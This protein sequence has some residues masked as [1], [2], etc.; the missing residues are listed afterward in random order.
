MTELPASLRPALTR[1][2]R[3]LAA[4]LFLDV[5]P[6]WAAAAL[7]VAG[8]VALVCRL[9]VPGAAGFLPWLWLAPVVAAVP[10][11]IV[12]A[13]RAFQPAQ[14]VA[15]ADSLSGGHGLLISMSER[16]DAAWSQSPLLERLAT[17]Q[18]PRLRPW[19]R[20][21]LLAP[22]LAFLAGALLLPQRIPAP[23][24]RGVLAD[25]IVN[26]LAATVVA[27]KKQE[28]LTPEEEKTLAEEIEQ[29]RQGASARVDSSSWEAADALKE[30]LA[31]SVGEKQDA[32]P[33]RARL[34]P[35]KAPSS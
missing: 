7:L 12:C 27:L 3:R 16:G 13:R 8:C 23:D 34:R 31:A 2:S 6:A 22:A 33:P 18:M 30:R 1:L 32:I 11:L 21:A 35:A 4:G 26:D 25:H 24:T 17:L 10:A 20:L 9:L 28:L 29:I 15:L 19:R 5:W 14:V